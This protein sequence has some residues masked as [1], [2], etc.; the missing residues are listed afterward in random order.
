VVQLVWVVQMG[1]MKMMDWRIVLLLTEARPG[2]QLMYLR[3]D[4]DPDGDLLRDTR[5]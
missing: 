2:H 5:S 1:S 3:Q 4:S